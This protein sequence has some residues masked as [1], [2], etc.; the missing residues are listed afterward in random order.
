MLYA[1]RMTL[2]EY[3]KQERGRM[4]N[5]AVRAGLAP[6]FLSQIANAVRNAPAERAADIERACEFHVRRWD[7]RPDD[8]HR[9]WPE[10]IG[11]DGAPEVPALEV[12]D[13]A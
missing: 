13:A 2:S 3:L 4:A 12:R 5:V 9:I 10:L 1:C 8:W 7:L 6:A 11:A